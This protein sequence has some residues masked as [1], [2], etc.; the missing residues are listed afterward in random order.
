MESSEAP[1]QKLSVAEIRQAVSREYAFLKDPSEQVERAS[2]IEWHTFCKVSPEQITIEMVVGMLRAEEAYYREEA[3]QRLSESDSDYIV[4]Y[5]LWEGIHDALQGATGKAPISKTIEYY[6]KEA[7][8]WKKM[9][10]DQRT[11]GETKGFRVFSNP[12][13]AA[14]SAEGQIKIWDRIAENC[15]AAARLFENRPNFVVA[16]EQTQSAS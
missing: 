2:Q 9:A 7:A 5:D 10:D 11:E 13:T 4:E 3:T 6:R 15:N 12:L 1:K 16:S 8:G 14:A